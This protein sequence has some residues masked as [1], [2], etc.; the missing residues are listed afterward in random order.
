MPTSK[1]TIIIESDDRIETIEIFKSEHENLDQ[2]WLAPTV[3]N[4]RGGLD[5]SGD[6]ELSLVVFSCQPQKD[7]ENGYIRRTEVPK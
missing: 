1:V 7:G 4:D 2:N 6:L 5:S 3:I